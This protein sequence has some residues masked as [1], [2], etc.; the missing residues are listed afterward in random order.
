MRQ[1]RH[2]HGLSA[3][4]DFVLCPLSYFFWCLPCY[5]LFGESGR[6]LQWTRAIWLQTTWVRHPSASTISN[7]VNML[8]VLFACCSFATVGRFMSG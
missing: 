3:D 4:G 5:F 1:E 6:Q 2:K 7:N 8:L